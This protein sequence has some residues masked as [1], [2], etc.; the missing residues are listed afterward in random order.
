M[1]DKEFDK[2]LLELQDRCGKDIA[3]RR[4]AEFWKKHGF[5]RNEDLTEKT[6][7]TNLSRY[8]NGKAFPRWDEF[9][10]IVAACNSDVV[11]VMGFIDREGAAHHVAGLQIA[12]DEVAIFQMLRTILDCKSNTRRIEG[13]TVNLE[14]F[15]DAARREMQEKRQEPP[16]SARGSPE[17][18]QLGRRHA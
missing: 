16:N 8:E 6:K 17:V 12:P 3:G 15:S 18:K 11:T 4:L 5:P 13:I 10:K 14:E 7:L 2:K 1:R 9:L